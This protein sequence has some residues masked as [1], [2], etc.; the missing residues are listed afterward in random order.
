MGFNFTYSTGRPVTAPVSKFIIAGTQYAYF[1]NRNQFRIPDYHR[2]DFSIS[3]AGSHKRKKILDGDWTFSIYNVYARKNA[4][5]IF[6]RTAQ[7]F[8]LSILGAAFPSLTYN[9]KI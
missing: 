6:F 2:L 7:T 5:S 8:K 3:L 1:S 4:Y 9:F